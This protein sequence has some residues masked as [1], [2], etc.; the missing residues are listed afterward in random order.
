MNNLLNK[1]KIK[2]PILFPS[3]LFF[4]VI[5][6]I[7]KI[8]VLPIAGYWQGIR[9]EDILILAF[10]LTFISKSNNLIYHQNLIYKNFLIFFIYIFISNL[11]AI[12]SGI[13]IKIV[14]V[15]RAFEYIVLLY[16]FDNF[17]ISKA[18]LKKIL[19][20]YLYINFFIAILQYFKLVGS[21]SSLGYLNPQ[22]ILSLTPMGLTGGSWELGA[23]ASIIFFIFCEI[24]KKSRNLIILFV[25][26]NLLLIFASG[27]GNFIAF[28]GACALLF[29]F[30]PKMD[31]YFKFFLIFLSFIFFMVLKSFFFIS[32][33]QKIFLIDLNYLITLFNQG[34][35]HNNLPTPDE[36]EDMR[37]YL[38]F[39]YRVRD[40]SIFIN[41]VTESNI[42][43]LFGIGLKHIYY[44]S[45]LIRLFVS[46]GIFGI[47]LMLLMSLR[48]KIYLLFFF[49]VS[50]AFLD[51][52]ISM[53][54]Y[55]FT[56]LMLYV[57]K[58]VTKKN[59][60]I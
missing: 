24:E 30:N 3:L 54:I 9:I 14:M 43:I 47:I 26:V 52:F 15:I 33:F 5:M 7:P 35:F 23:I 51:L 53:K 6:F 32:F 44:D 2:D 46:T 29:L 11:A 45:F 56:L 50:G 13:E 20:I 1:K 25:I 10:F 55:F 57:H 16:F 60:S 17:R 18:K 41:Q 58:H 27:R 34:I 38:S 36:L 59:I 40:W 28:N 12:F 42:N 19:Y 37:I 8:D 49:L 39:W 21:I 22:D 48:L 31:I 4:L